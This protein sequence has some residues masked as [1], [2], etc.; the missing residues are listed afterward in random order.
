MIRDVLLAGAVCV[1]LGVALEAQTARV[2]PRP[3]AQAPGAQPPGESAAP[4]GY[5]PIPQW[6]GQTR[7]PCLRGPRDTH[8]QTVVEGVNGAWFQFLPDGRILVA[9][10][11]GRIRIVSQDGKLSGPLGGMPSNMYAVGQSLYSVQPDGHFATNR[12]I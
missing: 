3:P 2:V 9:E 4:D 8:V 10:K 11:N 7:A 6:L 5:Q 1:G 12:M